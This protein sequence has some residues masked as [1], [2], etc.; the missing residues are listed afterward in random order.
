M[1]YVIQG[2]LKFNVNSNRKSQFLRCKRNGLVNVF[3]KNCNNCSYHKICGGNT[4]NIAN[5]ETGWRTIQ[6]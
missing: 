4:A 1:H 5:S 3:L 2:G 6:P